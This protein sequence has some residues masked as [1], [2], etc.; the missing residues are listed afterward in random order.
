LASVVQ[1]GILIAI[2][3]TVS[4]LPSA[5]EVVLYDRTTYSEEPRSGSSIPHSWY[6]VFLADGGSLTGHSYVVWG[7]EN[8]SK[9]RS[10]QYCF[11]LYAQGGDLKELVFGK[12]VGELRDDDC[13]SAINTTHRLIVKVDEVDFHNAMGVY[14]RWAQLEQEGRLEYEL[15]YSDCVTFLIEV[16]E[17]VGLSTPSRGLLF[18]QDYVKQLMRANE[19]SS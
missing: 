10:E 3:F 17:A 4:P 6:I 9:L 19:P 14:H 13:W 2:I 15:R 5:E 16:A 8:P 11:G 18:P 12:V 1:R 7:Q